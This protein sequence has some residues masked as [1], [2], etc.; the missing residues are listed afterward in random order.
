M[1][2][3]FNTIKGKLNKTSERAV[4]DNNLL[5]ISIV[6]SL[7][8]LVLFFLLLKAGGYLK[9]A[10]GIFVMVLTGLM[11]LLFVK[12]GTDKSEMWKDERDFSE[13][14]SSDVER[15]S[16]LIKRA[17]KGQ[18]I[19]KGMLERR[20]KKICLRKIKHEK[21]LSDEEL[22]K[23]LNK[24]EKLKKLVGEPLIVKLLCKEKVSMKEKG[25][26]NSIENLE[27][28]E[29]LQRILKVIEGGEICS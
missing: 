13:E 16:K 20:L 17:R 25:R 6:L 21:D 11:M 19:S 18:K 22:K 14:F 8:G 10:L 28:E 12:E 7:L 1:P 27:F 5:L 26:E 29:K 23:I 15:T 4:K 9:W 3:R 24:P 2:G